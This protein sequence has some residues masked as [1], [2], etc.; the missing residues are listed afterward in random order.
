MQIIASHVFRKCSRH[1]E[2]VIKI[3]TE[4]T[5]GKHS[6]KYFL[7]PTYFLGNELSAY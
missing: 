7:L 3:L 2:C 5:E 6:A 1:L 4:G